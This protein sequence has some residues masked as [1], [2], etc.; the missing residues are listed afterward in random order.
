VPNVADMTEADANTAITA[1]DNLTVG[2]IS[3]DYN[4]TITA[5]LVLSQSP[6]AGTA[7]PIGSTVDLI[8]SLGQPVVPNVVDM[9][10]P[11]A[12][13]VI[14][15]VDNLTIGN[16]S[17][18]YNDTITAGLVIRQN[19]AA[20]TS[21]PIGSSVDLV[22]SLGQP[23]VP[24]VVGMTE[25][26]AVAYVT[27]IDNLAVGSVTYDYNDTVAAGLV[28]SQSP[29]GSTAVPVGSSVDLV[30]SSGQPMVPNVVGMTEGNAST[31]ITAVDNLTV[32]SVTYD[33]NN[34]AVAGSVISQSPAGGTVVPIGSS[35]DLVVSLG[36]A[37]LVPRLVDRTEPNAIST[38]NDAG[39][40]VGVVTYEYS[41]TIAAGH[42]MSQDPVYAT[43]VPAGSSVDIVVSLGQAVDVP[44][45]VGGSEEDANSALT[46]AGLVVGITIYEYNDTV[47]ADVVLSQNPTGGTTVPAGSSIDLVV[48]LGQPQVPD[49]VGMTEVDAGLAITA[50]DNLTIGSVTYDYS[51]TVPIGLVMSQNPAAGTAVLIGSSIDLVVSLGQPVIIMVRGGN[52]LVDL[53]NSDGGWDRPLDDGD[54][55]SG[56]DPNTF[57]YVAMGLAEAYRQDTEANDPNVLAALQKANTF[58][59]S[60]TDSFV[61]ADG[62]LAAVFDSILGGTASVDY[63]R[64]NFYDKLEAGTYYDA[65]SGAVH[66]TN[67]Y[68]QS[69]RQRRDRV[70]WDVNLANLAAWDLGLG[71]QSAYVIG[72]NTT[73]WIAGVKAEIDELDGQQSYDVLGLAGAVFGLAATGED[74]DP[75]AG[76]HSSA[77]SLSDL[78]ATL[79]GYQLG[80]G[81]FTWNMASMTEGVDETI[82]ETVYG[83]MA[84]NEFDRGTYLTEVLDAGA[85]L[86]G[87]QLGTGGW[88]NFTTA[89]EEEENQITGEAIRGIAV[90]LNQPMVPDVVGIPEPNAVASIEAVEN[91][92]VGEITQQ[93]SDTVPAGLI[94]AQD[95]AAGTI[96]PIG[97]TVDMVVSLGQPMVPNVVGIPEPNATTAI[98]AVDNLI[99]G[100]I[101]Y[102]YNDTVASTVVISQNPGGGT[103]VAVGSPIDLVISLGQPM[104][105]NVVDLTEADANTEIT[106]V[107]NL[108][109]GSISYDYN[110]TVTSGLVVS[111][112]PT[113]GTSVPIGSTVDLVVSLGQPVA[114][115]TV[116]QTEADANVTVTAVDSLRVGNI[117][118]EYSGTVP[119]GRVIRQSPVAGTLVPI[120]STIDLVV[121]GVVV[122]DTVGM[123]LS[124][125]NLAMSAVGLPLG[126]VTYSYNDLTAAG[127][128]ISQNPAGG[129]AT[130]AGSSVDLAISLGQPVVPNVLG[131]NLTDANLALTNVTL[132]ISSITEVYSN[133]IPANTVMGQNPAGGTTVPVGSNVVLIVSLGRP[134]VPAVVGMLEADANL[135]IT[136]V[137]NLTV[138]SVL[139]QFSDTVA[140][141][142]VI[143]QNP[144]GGTEVL[145]GSAVD[146]VVSLGPP[147]P[148][149]DVMTLPWS[150]ANPI[151]YSAG[152]AVGAVTYEYHD[153]IPFSGVMDQDPVAD[154]IV[155][156][157]TTIDIVLSLGRPIVP[158]VVDM[159][160]PDANSTITSID[161][162]S[163]GSVAYVY[164]DTVALGLVV[165]QDPVADTEVLVGS[166]VD[167]AV[168]VGQPAAP[169]VV[170]MTET[171][172]NTAITAID[173]LTIGTVSYDYSDTIA[174]DVVISQ[175][176]AGGTTVAVGTPIDL[177]VS[178]GRPLVPYVVD[179]TEAEANLAITAVTLVP[180]S[181]RYEHH[182]TVPAGVVIS[183]SP[184]GGTTVSVGSSVDLVVSLGPPTVP[185]VV[186]MSEPDANSAITAVTLKIGAITYVRNDTVPAGTVLSQNPVG[187][188]T[189]SVGSSVDLTVSLAVVPD[190]VGMY[191]AD[192][193]STLA[194]AGLVIGYSTYEYSD[195]IAAGIVTAQ[196]PADGTE[197]PAGSAI[198]V[199]VSLGQPLDAIILGS[200]RLIELQNNDGGWD[201]PLDDG[202]PNAG[203]EP[204]T[205]ASIAMGLVEAYYL[206]DDPNVLTALQ[207]AKALLM[208]KTDNF[209]VND[210][211]FA[212]ELDIILGGSDCSDYVAANFYDML[213]VGAYY[214]A[215]SN[216]IHDTNSYIQ[217][218]RDH[219]VVQEIANHA[220]WDLGVGLYSAYVIGANTTEWLDG[221]KAEIDELNGDI[222][223][224]VIGL[225]GAVFGM[226]AVDED[227]DPQAGEHAAASSIADLADI[228]VNYQID[229]G[230]FTWHRTFWEEGLDERIHETAYAAMA[231]NEVNQTDYATEISDAAIFLQSVQLASGGWSNYGSGIEDNQSTGEA[232]RT[233]V[234]TTGT[235]I[236][237]DVTALAQ[238][239]ANAAIIKAGLTVG[240]LSVGYSDTIPAGHVISQDPPSPTELLLG[241]PVDLVI[242]QGSPVVP[243]VIGMTE[244]D[245]NLTLAAA[246]LVVGA[247]TYDYNDTV[248][249]WEV[250]SQSP[251]PGT[252]ASVGSPVD[253]TVSLGQPI[254]VPDIVGETEADANSAIAAIGLT[255]GTVVYEYND[256]V[257][258]GQVMSQSPTAGTPVPIRSPIDITVSG[259]IVPDVAGATEIEADSAIVG[260]GLVVGTVTYQYSDTIAEGIVMD[261]NPPGASATGIGSPV[262]LIVS[263]GLPIV[264]SVAG[265]TEAEANSVLAA[266]TLAV[267]ATTYEYSD[268]MPEGFVISQNPPA[269]TAVPIGS[270]VDLVVSS[271]QPVVP[272]VL[273]Q[274][275]ADATTAIEAVETLLVGTVT[276]QFSDTVAAGLVISQNPPG[277]TAVPIGSYVDLIVS[278]G[279]S[280][281]VPDVVDQ[282]E[283][284]ANS[285]VAAVNGLSVGITV[286]EYNDTVPMDL[287]IS[288]DPAG[289]SAVPVG[290][291]VDLVVS[292]G[293]AVVVPNVVDMNE[294]DA[295]S[296]TTAVGLVPNIIHQHSD[297]VPFGL[298]ISHNPPGGTTVS[299]G[300]PVDIYMSLGQPIVP[301]VLT[302]PESNAY[303]AIAGASLA[304]GTVSYQ[305]SIFPAGLVVGQN[306]VGGTTVLVG[307]AVDLTVSLGQPVTVPDVVGQTKLDANSVLTGAGLEIGAV[308]YEFNDVIAAAVIITQNPI[309][310][311]AVPAGS[312]IDLAI[313][314]GQ[315]AVAIALAGNRLVQLQNND[316]GWDPQLDDGDPNA[317]RDD[318]NFAPIA[319][320][321]AQAYRQTSD[322]N[323]LAALQKAK[324]LLLSKTD[325]FAVTDGTLAVE[326]DSILGGTACVD[327]VN[328]NFYDKLAAG[329]YYDAISDA[330]YSTATYV[331]ALRDPNTGN[332]AAWQLGLGLQS[333]HRIDA[334]TSEW[335]AALKAEIDPL[336]I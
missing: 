171:D 157:G 27:A 321:L 25:I 278:L 301:N 95:P 168:S 311:S 199:W 163:V 30:V 333:A 218:L 123:T 140:Q 42:V 195:T 54:P 5:G 11:N 241:S 276:P 52:R 103:T 150:E 332:L 72:A 166:T 88:E 111:Q 1:V 38:L 309:G 232:L 141:N 203:S 250:I 322:A 291:S 138:G 244:T 155:P 274:T 270:I 197:L 62:A 316:G 286:Y 28:L 73:E 192:A 46:A 39:L 56:S 159:T 236:V 10:E 262:D 108:T 149:P 4:D 319:M 127:H 179:R 126:D 53:Q 268:T 249:A 109:V 125:A 75:Q 213:A 290:T 182:D 259:V 132:V 227:Y 104:V 175:N 269:G 37:V 41:D 177:V 248:P 185:D 181:I 167:L 273:G 91:L 279:P 51:D 18:D 74:Y 94:I 183:Q 280:V 298:V 86:Q 212:V 67:S 302:T 106:A 180:G 193:N 82:Q 243:S 252:T 287:V 261:Q 320:G 325:N 242:S 260:A 228:L 231:L 300:T 263:A 294:P 117:T 137:D 96:M 114:P 43:T 47:A 143:S 136:A 196:S 20:T 275:L 187:G 217:A 15:A 233:M 251:T 297:S 22:V 191:K 50:V 208:S 154:T 63:V 178:L 186:G 90:A 133:I 100:T 170:G 8:V 253:L 61:P 124:D 142:V 169:N 116:G 24:D 172:A 323:M 89:T 80:S 97:S 64:A 305:Y 237:P 147:I 207:K 330:N 317:G 120:G 221:V 288:Q 71:L 324:L 295:N 307:T 66:D 318:V 264:P 205:L 122:P 176:P 40:V 19:P 315:P 105:P 304:V 314:L 282:N 36:E 194:A 156:L 299:I 153:T 284:Y 119:I 113:A 29:K 173:N 84:L 7:V 115:N 79:A 32:G 26:S 48:S 59:L 188:T 69:L 135:A 35:V 255:I 146:L 145:V 6:T 44:G 216:A 219:W 83:L 92:A 93:H 277:A 327:Y 266:D 144:A 246:S 118:Y 328:T 310:G 184:V 55:N 201:L 101:V 267:G 223:H 33:Y 164:S 3:Y 162:L 16:V 112:S 235:P 215:D 78:T 2:S 17:Y 131:T 247:V 234:I 202:D 256:T 257:P 121:S 230:G 210:G 254:I 60:K 271:G 238:A 331:Q 139:R 189:V 312:E 165:S 160:I 285:A 68:I 49:V 289:G 229:S 200:N 85:Y 226:A 81:G 129:A 335:I 158:Y 76:E 283:T 58:L 130:A 306:P 107:D 220:A 23:L 77:S 239:D 190:I 152:L 281:S 292:L 209:D 329:T 148:V 9:T 70:E 211:V 102:E 65:N 110:D 308:T 128:V 87:M 99:I 265:M 225:A 272:V 334:D 161:N 45:V 34:T 57:A 258:V 326:L 336:R 21:V 14:T 313:S 204:R 303:S 293:Q 12:M 198:D 174:A 134:V 224:D 98:T 31:T 222:G 245:A 151:I 206:V 296:A 214:D 240:T 13:T